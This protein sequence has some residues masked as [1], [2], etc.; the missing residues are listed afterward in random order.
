MT[1]NDRSFG[2]GSQAFPESELAG[3]S[4]RHF[5]LPVKRGMDILL[6][7][8]ALF[9]LA[10]LLVVAAMAIRLD[11]RGPILFRQARGGLNGTTFRIFKFRTMSV[12]EDGSVVRQATRGAARVTRVGFWLRCTSLDELPQLLN[13]LRG[14]MSLVGPRPH[15]VAHDQ[16]YA[17]L[18]AA[19]SRRHCM[20]PGITGWAQVNDARG[21]TPT[22]HHMRRRVDL[23]QWY[24]DNWSLAL[25]LKI[26]ART[27]TEIT[28]PSAAY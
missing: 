8:L 1:A 10:P 15:A 28:R 2:L 26:L 9:L 16:H 19:Y 20:R 6:A 5:A 27:V 22:I 7:T 23:D 14:D 11:S 3:P 12:A 4:S 17:R 25:D 13:V 18:L 21:E 24:V